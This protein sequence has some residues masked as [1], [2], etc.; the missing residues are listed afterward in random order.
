MMNLQMYCLSLSSSHL[1]L[2]KELE[3]LPVGL[4]DNNFTD[5]WLRDKTGQNIASRNSSYGEYTF[6][7]WL[8]KN[9]KI[10]F[11]G[12][13]GFCQYRK[14]WL[15]N[16][17]NNKINNFSDLNNLV[18][19]QIPIEFENYESILGE[20]LFINKIKLSKLL[21]HNFKTIFLNPSLILNENKRTIKF[22][23]DMMH[24]KGNMENA[25]Q[26]LAKKDKEDFKDFVNTQTSFNPHNMF[27]CKNKNILFN[28]Y[29]SLFPWL[30]ECEKI[31]G[32][33]KLNNYGLK[34]IYG[35]L[36]ERYMSFWFR[37]YT[38]YKVLP[39]YFKDLSDFL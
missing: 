36:A 26:L 28:Y 21:K 15:K 20:E 33:E 32:F 14:F 35:F 11:S 31:F 8:W 10:D 1:S 37:K 13:I 12:W 27:I 38:K 25:I 18:V 9:K 29:E 23:F 24:G 34:R 39:I 19:K 2:I 6:H 22:H 4:G 30:K 7:Y 16:F 17:N 3:Y 5:E